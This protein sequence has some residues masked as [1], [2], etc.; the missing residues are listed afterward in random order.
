[1]REAGFQVNRMKYSPSV[2]QDC[3]KYTADL[4][5]G[6]K[7]VEKKPQSMADYILQKRGIK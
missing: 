4:H 5:S 6:Q 1:M 3:I 2:I 7:V